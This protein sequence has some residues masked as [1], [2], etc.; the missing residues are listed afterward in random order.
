MV[1]PAE[2]V[3]FRR[4][5]SYSEIPKLENLGCPEHLLLAVSC[6][7]ELWAKCFRDSNAECGGISV[8]RFLFSADFSVIQAHHELGEIIMAQDC[9]LWYWMMRVAEKIVSSEFFHLVEERLNAPGFCVQILT[10]TKSYC[11]K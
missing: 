8:E 3:I 5:Q 11:R 2:F 7:C 4:L 9:E 6:V 10:W 1:F